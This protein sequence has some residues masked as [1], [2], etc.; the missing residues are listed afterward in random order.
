[1]PKPL[2]E[3]TRLVAEATTGGTGNRKKIQIITPGWGS[4][5]YYSAAVLER[6]ATDKV[7]PAGTHMYLNHASESER[8]DRPERDVEK[9]AA[10]LSED[11]TWDGSRLLAEAEIMGPHAELIDSLAPYIGVSISGSATDITIGEAE[12]R[13]GPIIEGLAHVASVDFVTQAGRGGMVLLESARPSLVNARAI[14][15]GISEA[16][17]NDTREQ[18]Q[19]QLRDAFGGEKSWVWVRDFDETTVWYEHETPDATGTF[20][21]GYELDDA[22][23]LSLSGTPVEVRA[24]TTYVPVNP[25]RPGGTTTTQE[26][27]EDTMGNIQIEEAEHRSLVEKAGRVPTLSERDTAQ[28]RRTSSSKELARRDRSDAARAVVTEKATAAGVTFTPLEERGLLADLPVKDGELDAEAF[29]KTVD[30]A[31]TEATKRGTTGSGVRGFGASAPTG[32][33]VTESR[34]TT[35]AWGRPSRRREPDP[36]PPTRSSASG[37]RSPCRCLR[38]RRPGPRS[39]SAASTASRP[40]TARRP[41]STRTTP[42]GRSTAAT[43]AAAA[44]STAT[45]RCGSTAPTTCPSAPRPRSPS[46]TR[47]TSRAATLSRPSPPATPCSATR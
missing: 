2:S 5:G 27:E 7:I 36:C 30:D 38:A 24:Q 14:S 18:L 21:I 26:S 40:P 28:E 13:T 47:S 11:A 20:A 19:Q 6:A 10:V 41:T 39:A 29:G 12:G 32:D 23:G 37:T 22:G 42:T 46:A 25:T 45:P 4:S 8:T 35:N 15:H 3:S 43:T 44:T 16:T 34:P 33:G 31:V 9:I 1:M 17:A